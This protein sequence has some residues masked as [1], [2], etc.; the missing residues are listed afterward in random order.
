MAFDIGNTGPMTSASPSV[1]FVDPQA[2][3]AVEPDPYHLSVALDPGTVI[4][5]MANGFPG[6]VEFLDHIEAALGELVAGLTFHRWNKGDASRLA[7]PG[8]IDALADRC[9][10]VI[11]AYGH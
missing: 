7:S 6:S 4:G 11:G 10:A 9:D 8:E 2:D 3:P 1:V 5:L